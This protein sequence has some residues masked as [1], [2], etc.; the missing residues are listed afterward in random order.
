M[1]IMP[2]YI[3]IYIYIYS[4]IWLHQILV[5]ALR[6]FYFHY[7]ILDIQLQYVKS[8]SSLTRNQTGP[9]PP[10]PHWELGVLPTGLPGKSLLYP[11]LELKKGFPGGTSGKEPACQCSRAEMRVPS[12]DR[13]DPWR[14]AWQPTPVFLSGE[15]HGQRS[16]DRNSPWGHKE[17]G[18]D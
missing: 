13:E 3:Y 14:R 7:S 17:S 12:L 15:F 5:A 6:I 11:L 18:H 10:H 2:I 16:L 1:A 4:F 9:P 8:I